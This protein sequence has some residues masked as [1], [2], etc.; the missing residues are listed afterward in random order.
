MAYAIV[1]QFHLIRHDSGRHKEYAR[2][3]QLKFL[4][5][6]GDGYVEAW[7]LHHILDYIKK[8]VTEGYS[9]STA[10]IED[11]LQ[12]KRLEEMLGSPQEQELQNTKNFIMNHRE[13][14]LQDCRG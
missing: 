4:R 14:I 6:K 2:E 1:A 8:R 3:L 9:Q 7:Y 11:V 5:K 10:S 12:G 13:E